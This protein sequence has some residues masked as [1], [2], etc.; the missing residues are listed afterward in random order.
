V[1]F[2]LSIIVNENHTVQLQKTDMTYYSLKEMHF[3]Q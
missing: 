3:Q 2:V 1:I